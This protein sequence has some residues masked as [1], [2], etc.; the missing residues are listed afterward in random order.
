MTASTD[1]TT[2]VIVDDHA[3]VRQGLREIL[4]TQA[5]LVVVGEA[6]DSASAVELV[7]EK[8]P[9][10]VLLDIEIPGEEAPTTVARMQALS[11]RSRV[12]ILSMYEGP[13]LLQSLLAA[14][15]R[16]YLLKSVHWQVLVAAI[17][18]VRNDDGRVVLEVSPESLV[19]AGRGSADLL[20]DREREVLELTAQAL[21]NSQIAARLSV[22]EATVKRHLHNIFAKLD[23]VS[24]ID[25]VNKARAASLIT[26]RRTRTSSSR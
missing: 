25:A 10:I 16:G 15:V 17:R 1:R 12:I 8:R 13:R 7:A 20:S 6:G 9:H 4:R 14:G 19:Q 26:T 22:T 21:S 24:R 5:D 23:A 18:A 11:P 3:L 2:I